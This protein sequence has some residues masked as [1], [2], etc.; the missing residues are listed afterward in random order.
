MPANQAAAL[1]RH[2]C[3]V[4]G[5]RQDACTDGALLDRFARQGDEAAFAALMQRHGALVWSVSRRVTRH[6]Q[7][8]E[9]V[10][11]ATFLL[12]ARKARAIRRRNSVG[13]FLYGVAYRLA[14]RARGN[15]ARRRQHEARAP[16]RAAADDDVTVRELHE[17]LAAELARLPERYRAPLLLCYFDGLTQEEAAQ[18]LGWSKRSMKYRLERGRDRLR[19]R[20]TRRGVE[21]SLVLA[22]SMLAG[23][24]TRA[25]APAALT[26]ATRRAAVPF[27]R[28]AA[29]GTASAGALAEG[30]LGGMG[31]GKVAVAVAVLLTVMLAGTAGLL[32]RRAG[33]DPAAAPAPPGQAD[34]EGV[35]DRYGDPLPPGAV[36]RLGTM[37]FRFQAVGSAFL[38]DGKAV[39][40]AVQGAIQFWDPRTGRLLREFTTGH[41][42]AGATGIG[43][44]ALSR[45]GKRL[46]VSGT[47]QGDG[48]PGWRSA[49][50][51]FD[52][53][54]GKAIRII[55]RLPLEGVNALTMSPDGKLLFTLDRNGKLRVEEVETGA[56]LLRQQFPGDVLACLTISPDGSTLALGSGPNTQR[57]FAWRWQAAEEPRA[58]A[59]GRYRGHDLAFSPDGK[60]LAECGD[61]EPD[62]RLLDVASGRLLRRLELPDHEPYRHSDVTFSPDGKL[63]AADGA[64][65]DRFAV[66]L[67]DAATGRFVQRLDVGGALAYSPDGTLL[68]VGSRVWDF[69]SGKELS[70]NDE[71]HRG[72]VERVV[73]GQGDLVVTAGTDNSIRVWE[74]TAGRQRL[75]IAPDALLNYSICCL[76]LSPDG[77]RIVSSSMRDDQVSLWDVATG[78]RIYRLAGH[79]KLGSIA[80]TAAFL[81]DG[82]S[83]VEWGA[84]DMYLR[85]WDVRTGKA[86]AEHLIRPT[87]V[88]I[89][90]EEDEPFDR[91][92]KAEGLSF[93]G[94]RFTP[95]GK[96]LVLQVNHK[97]FLFDTATG[98]ELRSFPG[99]GDQPGG[100]MAIS[101][102]GR[103]VLKSAYGKSVV[104]KLSD[105]ATQFTV[106]DNH[107]VTLWDL[108]TGAVRKQVVLPEQNPG[109]VAFSP[110]GKLFAVA[111][112]QPGTHIRLLETATGREVRKLEGFRGVVRSLAFMPDDRRLVSGMEDSSALVWDLTRAR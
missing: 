46:A 78:K 65:N 109:P 88:A 39:V 4:L 69:A 101:P 105:G 98:R 5:A 35:V 104:L 29:G 63:V 112:S 93:G 2:L 76:A 102:D 31:L 7:D 44:F 11:Q 71:A 24:V 1:L 91:E 15:A 100:D 68:L 97:F 79:G 84:A 110:D 83:F 106:P 70:A 43:G 94:A 60:L 34:D 86:L 111:S 14:L 108:E 6:E 75:R 26:E 41:F 10:Y 45:D 16:G 27:L 90:D 30:G 47:V 55:E 40:S 99:G 3:R 12:L 56:E 89:P 62:V 61:L 74:A 36:S 92:R 72:A 103:L 73:T 81:P 42:T 38:P 37:R 107:P 21:L 9:D 95:D 20:L 33:S 52:L 8:A 59:S 25:A 23:G 58:M 13:S 51:V 66:N 22:S 54:T 57:I 17:V 80:A 67:W 50:A 87:G 19:R 28:R 32:L 82:H 18:R 64:T 48:K 77:T 85:Q 53:T 96:R 49:A